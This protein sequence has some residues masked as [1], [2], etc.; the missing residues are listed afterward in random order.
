ML[1]E[2]FIEVP[3]GNPKSGNQKQSVVHVIAHPQKKNLR[4]KYDVT[5]EVVAITRRKVSQRRAQPSDS[6]SASSSASVTPLKRSAPEDFI[7]DC[8]LH[9]AFIRRRI[10]IQ[11]PPYSG[12]MLFIE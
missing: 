10:H 8:I 2:H 4:K 11:H 5:L 3:E 6:G 12:L 7:I 1:D 9:F